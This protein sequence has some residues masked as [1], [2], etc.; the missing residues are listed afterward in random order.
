[1][2]DLTGRN[3]F[4]TALGARRAPGHENIQQGN[5]AFTLRL[6][7]HQAISVGYQI[8]HRVAEYDGSIPDRKQRVETLFFTYTL[9]GHPHIRAVDWR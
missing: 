9:L 2:F 5:A 7:G 8:A 3:Y 1:M 6:F 4:I